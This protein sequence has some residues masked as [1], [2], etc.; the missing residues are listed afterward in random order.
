MACLRHALDTAW[1]NIDPVPYREARV[2]RPI[3]LSQSII[4][5]ICKINLCWRSLN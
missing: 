1:A 2:V 5:V 3:S 4:T